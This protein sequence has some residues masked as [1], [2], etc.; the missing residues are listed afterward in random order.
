MQHCFQGCCVST[1]SLE[2]TNPHIIYH[3]NHLT[4]PRAKRYERL[5]KSHGISP[6]AIATPPPSRSDNGGED[7]EPAAPA[8]AT[9]AGGNKRKTATGKAGAKAAPN[10]RSRKKAA[11]ASAERIV[12]SDGKDEEDEDGGSEDKGDGAAGDAGIKQGTDDGD[13]SA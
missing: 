2:Y 5:M 4:P 1:S 8:S 6:S 3:R 12:E 10:K 7:S 9:K 11:V 13:I